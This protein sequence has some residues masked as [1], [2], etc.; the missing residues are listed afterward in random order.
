MREPPLCAKR[1]SYL[2]TFNPTEIH[3]TY[4]SSDDS[5]NFLLKKVFVHE[6]KHVS[7]RLETCTSREYR[8]TCLSKWKTWIE[9]IHEYL[10]RNSSILNRLPPYFRWFDL[11]FSSKSLLTNPVSMACYI[12]LDG[13]QRNIWKFVCDTP[14]PVGFLIHYMV[15]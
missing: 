15:V 7:Y 5:R 1:L 10:R 3:S 9:L 6:A 4:K 2:L 11:L 12:Q 13:C 8:Q 14:V